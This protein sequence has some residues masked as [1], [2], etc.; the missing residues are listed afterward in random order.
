MNDGPR[1][2]DEVNPTRDEI[3]AWA[4][5][6]ALEP[7]QDWDI[8]IAEPEN[9]DLLLDLAR[10]AACPARRYLLGSLYCT[11]GH[12]DHDDPRLKTAATLAEASSDASVSTWGRRARHVLA[13]PSAFNRDDWCG[14]QGD[15]VDSDG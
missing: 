3:R 1:I 14:W 10:D 13:Y 2:V 15:L 7:M 5:S 4:Y 9:L 6:G 11:V 8:I 12:C